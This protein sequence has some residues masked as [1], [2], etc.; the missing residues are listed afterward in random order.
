MDNLAS[1]AQNWVND[2]LPGMDDIIAF[3]TT[4]NKAAVIDAAFTATV[5]G[6]QLAPG[7]NSTVTVG[8]NFTVWNGLTH[9]SG[10]INGDS[11][12]ILEGSSTAANGAIMTGIGTTTVWGNATFSVTGALPG[13]FT[14]NGRAFNV[15]AN[16]TFSLTMGRELVVSNGAVLT[17]NGRF[18]WLGGTIQINN[19][20]SILNKANADF[21]IECNET[22]Q[23][24]GTFTNQGRMSKLPGTVPTGVA[25]VSTLFNN[26]STG[27]VTA[28]WGT[29]KFNGGGTL[30]GNFSALN[31][32]RIE[33][34]IAEFSVGN[35]ATFSGPS[36]TALLPSAQFTLQAGAVATSQGTF[37]LSGT[38]SGPN[39][40]RNTGTFRW[41]MGEL[42]DLKTFANVGQMDIVA[43][44]PVVIDSSAVINTGLINWLGSNIQMYNNA[45]QERIGEII[46]RGIFDIKTDSTMELRPLPGGTPGQAQFNNIDGGTVK[47]TMGNDF[48]NI[49]VPFYQNAILE[50]NAR[51]IRFTGKYFQTHGSAETKIQNGAM[52]GGNDFFFS[53]GYIDIGTMGGVGGG[54]I[55]VVPN[56]TIENAATLRGSGLYYGNIFNSGTIEPGN[57]AEQIV[58][59]ISIWGEMDTNG[60]WTNGNLTQYSTGRIRL[61][62]RSTANNDHSFV[63]CTGNVA[64]AGTLEVNFL[65]GGAI[66][67]MDAFDLVTT[68]ASSTWIVSNLNTL[69]VNLPTGFTGVFDLNYLDGTGR[70]GVRL[71]LTN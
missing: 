49:Q 65:P 10:T 37:E 59:A 40:F 50:L 35:G 14:L 23:G 32:A 42:H 63:W 54:G 36:I 1:N 66:A 18:R 47:K 27:I 53:A 7:Y 15:N 71:T 25:T 64:L 8:R 43:L 9:M 30:G 12:L 31:L 6:M 16:A 13:G 17:N 28:N 39:E 44:I 68:R 62:V 51:M 69:I 45:N 24:Q 26:Q 67:N 29:L 34:D 70:R 4:S 33:F 5:A 60:V 58:G 22:V 19:T 57:V 61:G 46:N 41:L 11:D 38:I 21:D 2:L 3:D 52:H 20:S 55:L 48:T 56:L